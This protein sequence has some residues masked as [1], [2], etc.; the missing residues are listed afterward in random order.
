MAAAEPSSAC[1]AI[2][3]TPA[4][5]NI[6]IAWRSRNFCCS[7]WLP[8]GRFSG[9]EINRQ[10]SAAR[11]ELIYVTVAAHRGRTASF[12]SSGSAASFGI[13]E[14]KLWSSSRSCF[15]SCGRKGPACVLL[16]GVISELIITSSSGLEVAPTA[17]SNDL[18]ASAKLRRNGE[19]PMGN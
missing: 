8:S 9:V 12:S 4:A 13:R 10:E 3:W 5:T 15:S 16:G 18:R 14:G 17:R 6:D 2:R 7:I 19:T 1:A 11:N